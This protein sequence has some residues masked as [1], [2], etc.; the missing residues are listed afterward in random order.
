[1]H[2]LKWKLE[3]AVWK[4]VEEITESREWS[5]MGIWL[6]DETPRLMTEAAFSVLETQKDYQQYLDA[7]GVLEPESEPGSDE[8]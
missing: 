2:F 6:T 7:Q 3:E 5:D 1:M 8:T 4:W